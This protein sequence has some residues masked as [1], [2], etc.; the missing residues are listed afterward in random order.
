MPDNND[1]DDDARFWEQYQKLPPELQDAVFDEK[2]VDCVSRACQRTGQD[3]L[4]DFI[5]DK[6][7]DTYL[8][9]L[10]PEQLFALIKEKIA[11]RADIAQK[12][13]DEINEVL[14]VPLNQPLAKL[15][16][17]TLPSINSPLPAESAPTAQQTTAAKPAAINQPSSKPTTQMPTI[18]NPLKQA[19]PIPPPSAAFKRPADS[20][21]QKPP[22]MPLSSPSTPQ[23]P[24]EPSA[25]SLSA[26]PGGLHKKVF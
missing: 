11:S 8:G 25:S 22:A 20:I 1:I 18:N 9:N 17:K 13:I 23:M 5:I 24:A 14:L 10:P 6:V 19:S 21:P 15:Y 7:E 16:G 4:I 26:A 3:P 12:I 2:T